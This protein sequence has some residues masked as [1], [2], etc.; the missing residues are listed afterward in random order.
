MGDRPLIGKLESDGYVRITECKGRTF[1][2]RP[3]IP[4]LESWTK[5]FPNT[6]YGCDEL[7]DAA[8][9]GPRPA[10]G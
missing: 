6:V 5:E 8:E 10:G 3:N 2:K 9:G 4:L 1:N 7:A